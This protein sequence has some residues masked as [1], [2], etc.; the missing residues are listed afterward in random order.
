MG[1]EGA[2][3]ATVCGSISAVIVLF[4]QY[5]R[6]A[7]VHE[8]S[9][10]HSFR[11]DKVIMKK[12]LYFGYPAGLEMFLNFLAFSTM[13]SL[14][15]SQGDSVATASTIM[16]NW[17]LVSFIPLLGI[18]VAVTSLVGRY[19]GAGKPETAQHA[20]I[21]AIKTGI[22]YSVVILG[23]FVFIPEVL[24][25]V[26]SPDQPGEIFEKAVPIAVTMI[27]IASIYVLVE[28]VFVAMVGALRG[29]GDTHFTMITSV[30]AHWIFVPILYV[31]FK[32]F[33]F[34]AAFGWFL[35]VLFFL[36]FA[37]IIILRFSS[38]KWKTIR[39]IG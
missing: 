38:G 36:V 2:A 30:T 11:F 3:I 17:D 12:L 35:L 20:A 15:H 5:F 7:N 37:T 6:A 25:R 13:I 33:H 27:Q 29:A 34:S 31:S 18:E 1:I 24:V 23:L 22:F 19:M 39:V 10:S 8:F 21:S 16:F 26:F 28:A 9:V 4:Y 14:F 32:V